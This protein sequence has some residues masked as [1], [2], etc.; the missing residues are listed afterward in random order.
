MDKLP[1]QLPTD[2]IEALTTLVTEVARVTTAAD[3]GRE[4]ANPGGSAAAQPAQATQAA[5]P[6][7]A[8]SSGPAR[9]R[10]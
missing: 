8:G 7:Q 2:A 10:P 5:R 6:A 1:W 4:Q 9:R 3:V